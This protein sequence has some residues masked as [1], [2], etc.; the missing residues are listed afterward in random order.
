LR[1]RNRINPQHEVERVRTWIEQSIIGDMLV[2]TE[3][4]GYK[5]FNGIRFP[6]RIVQKTDSF[7]S[8]DLT[9][10]TV[11]ANAAV[12]I[13]VPSDVRNAPVAPPTMKAQKLAEGIFWLTGGTHHS[14]VIEMNDHLV[15][16]DTPN[17]EARAMAVIAKAKGPMPGKPIRYVIAMHQ[18]PRTSR[19]R[20]L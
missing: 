2:E 6:S 18:R 3:Y 4:S 19:G 11:T 12:D 9:V 14:L 16:V 1:R 10:A 17:G 5:D 8:L 15:L 13:T 7:P 20:R